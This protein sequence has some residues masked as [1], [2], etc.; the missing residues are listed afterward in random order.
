MKFTVK[1]LLSLLV[2]LQSVCGYANNDQ[3]LIQNHDSLRIARIS[4]FGKVWGVINYFHPAA[5]KGMLSPDSLVISNICRLLDDPSATGF[6]T[7]I[8]ALFSELDDPHSA[9]SDKK[10]SAIDSPYTEPGLTLTP[11]DSKS[12]YHS[13]SAYI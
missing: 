2:I 8:S 6:K 10:N 4:D 13:F 3:E 9:I 1:M 12:I 7:A 11:L 5:G